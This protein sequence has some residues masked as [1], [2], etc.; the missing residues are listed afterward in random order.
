MARQRKAYTT[1]KFQMV[2]IANQLLGTAPEELWDRPVTYRTPQELE[3]IR[4]YAARAFLQVVNAGAL[5][6][7]VVYPAYPVILTVQPSLHWIEG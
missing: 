4:E 5:G 2:V 6:V 7:V 1:G 3:H